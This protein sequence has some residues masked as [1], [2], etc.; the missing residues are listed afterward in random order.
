MGLRVIA[1][2]IALSP[3]LFAQEDAGEVRGR[4]VSSR[5]NEALGQVQVSLTGAP[6]NMPLRAVT[7]DD[8]SF[9]IPAVPPGNYVLQTAAVDFYL[10]RNEFALAAGETKTFD[11]ILT[12]STD[13]RKDTVVVS[14]GAFAVATETNSAAITL[15]GEERKNLASV[16]ADDPLR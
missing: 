12:S 10:V 13:E 3:I 6:L 14:A 9:R 4:V 16:L 8:G 7:S 2:V 1:A 5:G 15:E 11:V